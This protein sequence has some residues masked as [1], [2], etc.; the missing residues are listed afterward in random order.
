METQSDQP[1]LEVIRHGFGDKNDLSDKGIVDRYK[2]FQHAVAPE[3]PQVKLIDQEGNWLKLETSNF[4]VENTEENHLSTEV[5]II[6]SSKRGKTSEETFIFHR[7]NFFN[8]QNNLPKEVL[9]ASNLRDLTKF[10]LQV[11]L[12]RNEQKTIQVRYRTTSLAWSSWSEERVVSEEQLLISFSLII[13]MSISV[14]SVTTLAA[15]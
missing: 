12:G 13:L 8:G 5:K 3:T 1:Y 11:R 14:L 15:F 2:I 9:N 7:E 6:T 4:E 10:S